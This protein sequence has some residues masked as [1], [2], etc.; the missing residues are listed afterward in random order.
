MA[1]TN[2]VC[3]LLERFWSCSQPILRFPIYA[4]VEAPR[5]GDR[6][7]DTKKGSARELT[8][9][10]QRL[11]VCYSRVAAQLVWPLSLIAPLLRNRG[12]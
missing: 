5:K 4:F 3:I 8:G 6:A 10:L 7:V 2:S 11:L 9:L 12:G 1:V